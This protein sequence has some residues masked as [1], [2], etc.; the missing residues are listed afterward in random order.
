[1]NSS[2]LETCASVATNGWTARAGRPR[3][4]RYHQDVS[5]RSFFMLYAF[6]LEAMLKAVWLAQGNRAVSPSSIE[7]EK[8]FKRDG[9]DLHKWWHVASMGAPTADELAVLDFLTSYVEIGRYPVRARAQP[10]NN[11][12]ILPTAAQPVILSMLDKALASLPKGPG[13]LPPRLA[14]L[15]VR[16]TPVRMTNDG[17]RAIRTPKASAG[18]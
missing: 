13:V 1:M 14:T 5:A 15:G 18:K 12:L 6:A 7:L 2:P 16:R 4:V 10:A 17:V 3:V 9:H 11:R 8:A